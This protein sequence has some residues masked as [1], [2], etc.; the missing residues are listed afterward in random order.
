MRKWTRQLVSITALGLPLLGGILTVDAGMTSATTITTGGASVPVAAATRTAQRLATAD[1][2]TSLPD[3]STNTDESPAPTTTPA[4][5]P[6]AARV[7]EPVVTEPATFEPILTDESTTHPLV[8]TEGAS[9]LDPSGVDAPVG[10]LPGWKQNF[11]DNFST[12]VP[13]GQF[14]QAVSDKWGA[15]PRPWTDTTNKGNYDPQ[16]VV[17][18]DGGVLDKHLR[19]DPTTGEH[20][21]AALTPRGTGTTDRYGQ[22][23]GRYSVRMRSDSMPGYKIAWLLWPDVG[24]NTKG[25]VFS[26]G[27][28]DGEIDFPETE[29]DATEVGLFVHH[30]GAVVSNDQT[31][32][33]ATV[34][35]REWH[36]YT[37]EWSPN[38]V[39][40]YIDGVETG[41]VTKR[42]PKASMHWVIQTE[43]SIINATPDLTSGHLEIDW[44]AQWSYDAETFET[45]PAP[46]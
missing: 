33:K 6:A 14:P 20:L 4:P 37:F 36:T 2:S 29:L 40:A 18:I 34:D 19:T 38:L 16:K 10:D 8:P 1:G 21:V 26:D 23:Y 28:G 31:V 41:R 9:P 11:L 42:I 12:D 35:I 15:Y 45:P 43:T 25:S 17:S 3:V 22:L 27:G 30:Q 7:D 44:I 24:T 5:A 13:L 39:V 46:T 32:R